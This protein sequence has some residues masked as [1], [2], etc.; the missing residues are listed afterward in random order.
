M[1][2]TIPKGGGGE[3]ESKG[4]SEVTCVENSVCKLLGIDWNSFSDEFAFDFSELLQHASKLSK[5]KRSVLKVTTSLFDLLGLLSPF[6]ITLKV[7]FQDLCND[8]VNWDEP[9]PEELRKG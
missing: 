8:R 6:V 1:L 7:M 5:T 2:S 9:L 4:S 3:D